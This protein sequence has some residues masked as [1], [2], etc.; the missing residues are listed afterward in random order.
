MNARLLVIGGGEDRHDDKAVLERFVSL[1]GGA[2]ARI[3]VVTAA[4]KVGDRVWDLYDDAFG[5]LG[6]ARRQV[7]D[8]DS[9]AAANDAALAAEVAAADGIFMTGGDQKRL[10]ALLGGTALEAAMHAALARGA[11]VAGTSA[12]ASAMSAHMLAHGRSQLTPEK[13]MVGLGA[14][15]GFIDRVV[16]DQHF[17]ERHR[18]ARLLTVVAQNPH[19]IGIGIDEDTAL[20]IEAGSAIEVIGAGTVT[21]VD[22]R[23]MVSNVVD[24]QHRAVPE[25]LDVRLHILPTGTRYHVA[26]HA[27]GGARPCPAA[28]ADFLN[29]VTRIA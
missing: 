18:L 1:C 7:I 16:V 6:V 8:A 3:A 27:D 2:G 20:L 12:G 10:L 9:R 17:S 5:A 24:V 23:E 15:F 29:I 19:L 14:G 4:S 13:G 21:I 26:G 25:M 28:L 22:G 11:C